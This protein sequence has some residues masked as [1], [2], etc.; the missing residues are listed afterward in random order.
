MK[1]ARPE[2]HYLWKIISITQKL[3]GDVVTKVVIEV[4]TYNTTN[5]Q[6]HSKMKM[7]SE[8]I[9]VIVIISIILITIK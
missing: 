8:C 7:D 6:K 5:K 9:E 4:I 3:I 1:Q 2:T